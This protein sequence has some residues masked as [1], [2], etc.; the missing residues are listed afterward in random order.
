MA[1]A[2]SWDMAW[3]DFLIDPSALAGGWTGETLPLAFVPVEA[4]PAGLRIA[5]LPPFPV[6]GL[7]DA[8]SPNA[9][10]LDAILEPPC[11]ADMLARAIAANP[12]AAAIAVQLL[13]RLEGSEIKAA[14][15]QESLAYGLLQGSAEHAAWLGARVPGAVSG[16]GRIA[17]HRDADVLHIRLDRTDARNAIDRAMRD[18]L[19]ELFTLAALDPDLVKVRLSGAGKAF[20][21]G[22]DLGEFGTTRDSATAH[23]IR[24]R[25][26]PAHAIA[27]SATK[28]EVHIQGACVGAGLEM[29]AFATRISAT[30]NAWFHLP[31]LAMGLIPGAGGCVSVSRRIGRQRAALMILSGRRITAATALEW[32]LVDAIVDDPSTGDGAADEV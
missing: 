5:E 12:H 6:I 17:A 26:L 18:Q 1:G 28:L 19:H 15:F 21:V 11:T 31:E 4:I 20:C 27:R 23:L 3:N 10:C 25:T 29:A 9:A 32:G 13:R 16:E 8:A 22:A 14:L 2:L 24:M 30:G 7:G